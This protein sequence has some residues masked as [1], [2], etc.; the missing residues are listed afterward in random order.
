MPVPDHWRV[1]VMEAWM[2][3]DMSFSPEQTARRAL[4]RMCAVE[5][6]VS[7]YHHNYVFFTTWKNDV[8]T[9]QICGSTFEASFTERVDQHLELHVNQ[10]LYV[11]DSSRSEPIWS[12]TD[13]PRTA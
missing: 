8:T 13:E 1:R 3:E 6:P 4:V 11:I 10:V 2:K 5:A 7:T 9:C 12:Y